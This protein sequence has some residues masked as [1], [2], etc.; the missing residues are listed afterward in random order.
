[1][2]TRSARIGR[3]AALDRNN[4]DDGA[5]RLTPLLRRLFGLLLRDGAAPFT[6]RSIGCQTAPAEAL[7]QVHAAGRTIDYM[8]VD[9]ADLLPTL[10]TATQAGLSP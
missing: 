8:L 10:V 9:V 2:F 3:R 1:M 6:F 4:Q 5:L 7:R